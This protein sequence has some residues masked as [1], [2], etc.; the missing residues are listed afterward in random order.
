MRFLRLDEEMVLAFFCKKEGKGEGLRRGKGER[1]E[2][3]RR[4]GKTMEANATRRGGDGY[5]A[6]PI[7]YYLIC[8][9]DENVARP[10][11]F[12]EARGSPLRLP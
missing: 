5:D 8:C 6:M 1:K 12:R 3:A 2:E 10:F 9:N 7:Q 4:K 11:E